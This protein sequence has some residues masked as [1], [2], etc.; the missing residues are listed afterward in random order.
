MLLGVQQVSS[1]YQMPY[2]QTLH[3]FLSKNYLCAKIT[4]HVNGFTVNS[5]DVVGD[6]LG[7]QALSTSLGFP[8]HAIRSAARGQ[9]DHPFLPLFVP[10]LRARSLGWRPSQPIPLSPDTPLPTSHCDSEKNMEIPI[11]KTHRR[12]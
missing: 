8:T 9:G 7:L 12:L 11:E 10:P 2:L 3:W 4:Q 5:F 1:S 6:R